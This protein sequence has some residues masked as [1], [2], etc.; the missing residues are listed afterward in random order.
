MFTEEELQMFVDL[1]GGLEDDP[2]GPEPEE[3]I[4]EATK[5]FL[6]KHPELDDCW[7]NDA[8]DIKETSTV[9]F[10]IGIK[11]ANGQEELYTFENGKVTAGS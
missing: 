11:H 5:E 7:L 6:G 2:E 4:T 9:G 3:L 8:F 1:S 10:V